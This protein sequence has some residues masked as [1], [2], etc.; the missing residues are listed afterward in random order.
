MA[1]ADGMDL[2][3]PTASGSRDPPAI[4][5]TRDCRPE[6][7]RAV[8]DVAFRHRLSGRRVFWDGGVPTGVTVRELKD[9]FIRN[10]PMQLLQGDLAITDSDLL[11]EVLRGGPAPEGDVVE[12]SVVFEAAS[13]PGVFSAGANCAMA[14]RADDQATLDKLAERFLV[15]S[16]VGMGT[17]ANV[18]KALRQDTEPRELVAI[19]M[20]P[21]DEEEESGGIPAAQIREVSL[22]KQVDHPNVVRMMDI[23]TTSSALYLVF[24][25]M[26]MDLRAFMRANPDHFLCPDGLRSAMRQCVLGLHHCHVR[27]IIHR[28]L[29]PQNVLVDVA[30]T[31][32]KLADFGLARSFT[33][34]PRPY[35]PEVVTLWYRAPELLLGEQTSHTALDIWS[36]A[37]LAA[38]MATNRPLFPGDS[39][40]DTIFRIF[41]VLGTPNET[42][43]PGVL[44]LRFFQ[45]TFPQW[46]DTRL[47]DIATEGP[48]LGEHGIDLLRHCL[49]YAPQ[50]RLT[51]RK[52]LNH[53]FFKQGDREA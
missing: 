22:V 17:F 42:V 40:I 36:L 28:D 18:Y 20:L 51:A 19:K 12:F 16:K 34:P 14:S 48:A 41:R 26:D 6:G 49:A 52:I 33:V 31:T 4:A 32:L 8:V 24:E 38:E 43:W 46:E 45:S 15:L 39:E 13:E 50:E 44:S 9:R 21:L 7:V 30:T 25:L 10:V 2:S 47:A 11:W 1:G 53:S 37:C 27:R 35:T 29:K 5:T 3:S 23:Y